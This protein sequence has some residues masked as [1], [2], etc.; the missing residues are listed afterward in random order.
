MGGDMAMQ[1]IR[2]GG[3]PCAQIPIIALTADAMAG[4]RERYIALGFDDHI[5]K[6]IEPGRFVEVVGYWASAR[7]VE[8]VARAAEG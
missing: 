8:R 5:A 4:D 1:A 2:A 6:P 3:G 7:P